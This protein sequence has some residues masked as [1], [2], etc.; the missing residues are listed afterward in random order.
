VVRV[1]LE[2]EDPDK[3]EQLCR[4]LAGQVESLLAG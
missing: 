1:M 4:Q 2:G 3:V